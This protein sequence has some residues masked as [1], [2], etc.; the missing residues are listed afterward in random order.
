MLNSYPKEVYTG[1]TLD[2]CIVTCYKST[3]QRVT[4]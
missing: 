2:F 4:N 1:V 3:N